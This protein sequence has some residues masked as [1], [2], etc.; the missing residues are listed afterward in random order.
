MRQHDR[1]DSTMMRY[2]DTENT[3][4]PAVPFLY[5]EEDAETM[6]ETVWSHRLE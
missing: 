4:A 3:G 6:E 5:S 2:T 1:R